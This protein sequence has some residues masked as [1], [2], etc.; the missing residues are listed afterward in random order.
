MPKNH[1]F[2]FTF[3]IRNKF[4]FT[5]HQATDPWYKAHYDALT[6]G[7]T[8]LDGG[9]QANSDVQ[10]FGE[11]AF[12]VAVTASG[13]P[14]IAAAEFGKVGGRLGLFRLSSFKKRRKPCSIF[15]IAV[16]GTRGGRR[17]E[18]LDI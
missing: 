4:Q 7:L 12:A 9:G 10:V 18:E 11:K 5:D 2:I 3:K 16:P 17:E 1:T 15:N 8:S 14:V 13:H 6:A